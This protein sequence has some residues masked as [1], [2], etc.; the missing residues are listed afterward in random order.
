MKCAWNVILCKKHT[1]KLMGGFVALPVCNCCP[2]NSFFTFNKTGWLE[3]SQNRKL[4][5]EKWCYGK[6][7]KIHAPCSRK[8]DIDSKQNDK[9]SLLHFCPKIPQMSKINQASLKHHHW[10]KENSWHHITVILAK[11]I[12]SFDLIFPP[13]FRQQLRWDVL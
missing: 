13:P 6:K 1:E 9:T 11:K 2:N 4:N 5:F 8:I 12:S 10:K 7:N 3:R